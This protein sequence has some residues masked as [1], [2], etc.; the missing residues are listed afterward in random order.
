MMPKVDKDKEE[1]KI[2]EQNERKENLRINREKFLLKSRDSKLLKEVNDLDFVDFLHTKTVEETW[3]ARLKIAVTAHIYFLA[4][5]T[6]K[7]LRLEENLR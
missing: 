6:V 1:Q 3:N 5:F 4:G 7:D 2:V